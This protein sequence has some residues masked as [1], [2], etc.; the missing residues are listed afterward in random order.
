MVNVTENLQLRICCSIKKTLNSLYYSTLE[1]F[2]VSLSGCKPQAC[3]NF[4]LR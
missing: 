3:L 2:S 4:V 1:H